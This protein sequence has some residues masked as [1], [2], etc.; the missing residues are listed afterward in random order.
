MSDEEIDLNK[1]DDD[2][3]NFIE[4]HTPAATAA[5]EASLNS[6]S[7]TAAQY[8]AQHTKKR[9]KSLKFNYDDA[10]CY[11]DEN[12]N[13]IETNTLYEAIAAAQKFAEPNECLDY[14]QDDDDDDDNSST[15]S[16]LPVIDQISEVEERRL[17]EEMGGT[18]PPTNKAETRSDEQPEFIQEV[19]SAGTI[20]IR[21]K[22]SDDNNGDKSAHTR[23]RGGIHQVCV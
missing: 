10:Y 8:P 14:L 9:K 5:L 2:D 21:L 15:S 12:G 23:R 11:T 4:Q 20:N 1:A 3:L 22:T 7:S 13:E 16:S 18:L 19:D 6:S 17:F